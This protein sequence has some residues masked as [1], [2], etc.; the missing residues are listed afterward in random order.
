MVASLPTAILGREGWIDGWME[1]RD[2]ATS[3]AEHPPAHFSIQLWK[4]S[5]LLSQGSVNG[6]QCLSSCQRAWPAP[7][8]LL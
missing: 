7:P 6:V 1:R 8:E 2:T 5:K 4:S 3:Q